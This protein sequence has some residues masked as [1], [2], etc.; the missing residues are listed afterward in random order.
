MSTR[1]EPTNH[2]ATHSANYPG[3]PS[4]DKVPSNTPPT[5]EAPTEQAVVLEAE[6]LPLSETEQD[7]AEVL[8]DDIMEKISV[9][10]RPPTHQQRRIGWGVVLIMGLMMFV[11]AMAWAIVSGVSFG[12]VVGLSIVCVIVLVVMGTPVWVAGVNRGIE[13]AAARNKAM[14]SVQKVK[15]VKAGV[16]PHKE[17]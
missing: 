11:V 9:D 4:G 6:A 2:S 16:L 3:S 15:V 14:E 8:Q 13:E 17:G 5:P 1:L 12:L 7:R 10:G